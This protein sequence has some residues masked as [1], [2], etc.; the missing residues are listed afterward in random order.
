MSD[1]EDEEPI[2]ILV[3]DRAPD[4]EQRRMES[5]YDE[6]LKCTPKTLAY[7]DEVVH[8][9]VVTPV[10]IEGKL[11]LELR[12]S[13]NRNTPLSQSEPIATTKEHKIWMFKV[14]IEGERSSQ[15]EVRA[16]Y[17]NKGEAHNMILEDF[18][19]LDDVIINGIRFGSAT[20]L[21]DKKEQNKAV[22][23]KISLTIT[24]IFQLMFKNIKSEKMLISLDVCAC[25]RLKDKRTQITIKDIKIKITNC[26]TVEYSKIKYPVHLVPESKIT[27]AYV[28]SSSDNNHIKPVNA[29]ISSTVDG[30]KQIETK[31]TTNIDFQR[32]YYNPATQSLRNF[33]TPLLVQ[34]RTPSRSASSV[35]LSVHKRPGYKYKSTSSTSMRSSSQVM[36]GLTLSVSGKTQVKLSEAFKWKIQLINKSST[37][38]DLILYIQSSVK[39]QY[40]KSLV[41]I[42]AQ[43]ANSTKDDP[44]PLYKNSQLVRAFYH[45]FNKVGLVSLTNNLR[46]NLEPGNLFETELQL[47]AIERGLFTL[48]DIK[49]LDASTGDTFGCPRLLDVLVI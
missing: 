40:E 17:K 6:L 36:R 20:Q 8:V 14:R 9:F 32:P 43:N 30:F 42:S 37:K 12:Y 27:L 23:C 22:S 4:L 21:K 5:L 26:E 28:L 11:N 44:V 3:P 34:S 46:M 24:P 15:L 41:P 10:S 45:K 19:P 18:E 33:S 47:V 31:W 7:F 35:M 38:M 48:R 2:K 29:L 16:W 49:I 39:K 25:Q 13:T 1:S